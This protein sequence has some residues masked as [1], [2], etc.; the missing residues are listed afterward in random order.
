MA[1]STHPVGTDQQAPRATEQP[2]VWRMEP[3]LRAVWRS[4]E[5]DRCAKDAATATL[6]ACNEDGACTL[7]A[8]V[9]AALSALPITYLKAGWARLVAEDWMLVED[10][11]PQA[12][13]RTVGVSVT[14]DVREEVIGQRADRLGTDQTI[15]RSAGRPIGRG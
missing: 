9:V 3:V 13:I 8:P 12:S 14:G 7:A 6:L 4:R 5:L 15:N 11:R 10:Q 1:T 2:S